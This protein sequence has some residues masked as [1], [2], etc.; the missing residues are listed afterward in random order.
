MRIGLESG[1][2]TY[3]LAGEP[4]V[5]ESVHSSVRDYALTGDRQQEPVQLVKSSLTRQFDRGNQTNEV[6]FGTTR[7]FGT[8]D[9]CF[10]YTLDYLNSV[11]LTGTLILQIDTPGGGSKSRLIANAVM[12]RPEFETVGV[13]LTLDYTVIGG[14]ITTGPTDP[15]GGGPIIPG[16][17][18]GKYLTPTGGGY[19]TP[20][21]GYYTTGT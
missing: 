1:G 7:T 6:S 11:P 16:D 14:A 4:G 18:V 19:L 8:S 5:S 3:W 9:L 10:L 12:H 20:T 21:G 17:G 13:S 2:T 15:G